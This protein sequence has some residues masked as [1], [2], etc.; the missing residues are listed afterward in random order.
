MTTS[1]SVERR[2]LRARLA[3][4]LSTILCSGLA[5]PAFASTPHPNLDTNDVD[6]TDGTFNPRLPIYAIGSGQGELSLV[7]TPV[8]GNNALDNWSGVGLYQTV[9]GGVTRISISLGATFDT[10]TS[11]DSYAVSL[12][13]TGATLSTSGSEATYH[14]LDGVTITFA[15]LNPQFAGGTTNFCSDESSNF[16]HLLPISVAGKSGMTISYDWDVNPNCTPPQEIDTGANCSEYWRLHSVSNDAGYG[17]TWTY[18][19]PT[20]SPVAAYFQR[21]TATFSN[22]NVPGTSPV[23]TYGYPSSGVQTVTTPGGKVWRIAA[24]SGPIVGIRRPG[25]SNDTTTISYNASATVSSVTNNGITTNYA[26]TVSGSTATM[27]VTDAQAHATTIVSD[28]SK[29]RPTSVTDA[30]GRITTFAYDSVGKLTEVS[31]PEGD[32]KQLGYDAASRTTS[33]TLKAKP[34]SGLSD[35]MTSTSYG[36]D[37]TDATCPAWSR[38]A[39]GHQTDFTYDGTTGLIATVTAPAPASGATRPETRYSYSTVSGIAV[40]TGVSTC[41]TGAAPSCVSTADEVKTTASY[42]SNLLPTSSSIG[43]GDGSLTATTTT[44]YDNI[45]NLIS[46]DGPLLGSDDTTTYRYDP[47]R[48]PV[49]AI[50]ADPDGAGAL[51]RRAV[52]TAYNSDGQPTISEIGNV[53]G[54]TESDWSAFVTMQQSTASYDANARKTKDVVTAGGNTYQVTQYSYDAVG[55]LECSALRMNGATWGALPSSACALGTTGAFGPDRISKT[56]YNAAGEATKVQSAYGTSDQADDATG[57]YN[58]NGT[59]ATLTDAQSNTTTYEYDGFDRLVRTRYPVATAGSVAS[60]TTD[61]EQLSYDAVG[62]VT[63]RRLRDAT[64]INYGYDALNR[65]KT[66][67]LPGSELDLSYGYDLLSRPVSAAT[68][69]QTLAFGYDAL[70][71]NVTQTSPLGTVTSA[72]DIAGRRTRL[73]WPD[74]FYVTYDYLVTGETSAIRENGATSGVGVLAMFGY[75]NLGRRISLT[76]GNGAVTSYTPDAVSRLSTL[77]HSFPNSTS[78]NVT[79]TFGYTPAAQIA[80]STR[81]NDSY[82]WTASANRNDASAVNGLNQA[83]SVGSTSLGYDARGN[84]TSNGSATYSYSSE[85]LLIGTNLGVS[86]AYD[87]L[88]RLSRYT[89]ASGATDTLY[90][91]SDAV[92]DLSSGS[93]SFRYVWGPTPD[94]LLVTYLGAN[95]AT[96]RFWSADE[97]G[98][99]IAAS[100]ASGASTGAFAYDEYGVPGAGT[101]RF[102]YTGQRWLAELGLN[103]Y[104]ARMYAPSLGRFMQTDPIGYGAGMN[105]YGY[106]GSDPINASDPSGLDPDDI[107]VTGQPK[108]KATAPAAT[109]PNNFGGF[110]HSSGSSTGLGTIMGPIFGTDTGEDIVV[111]AT[112]KPKPKP[113]VGKQL[114]QIQNPSTIQC[115]GPVQLLAGNPNNVGK[116]G[117]NGPIRNGSAAVVPSQFTGQESQGPLLRAIGKGA[118]GGIAYHNPDGSIGGEFF[119]GIDQ[120]V[121]NRAISR[122]DI[123]A[124]ANGNLVI[125]IVGGSHTDYNAVGSFTFPNYGQGCP[126]STQ[127]GRR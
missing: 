94:E 123:V 118:D 48:A 12:R 3:L 37:C 21:A 69:V 14:T 23:V 57:T 17:I 59:L 61:Y 58:N 51:K 60:S 119:V 27:V 54:T 11:A 106:V 121:G 98:S 68:T 74:A 4:T 70:G 1:T 28:M 76:R 114:P 96:R 7:A 124:R 52:R 85:N 32:K 20:G 55:R 56:T 117:F 41:Q 97:R 63:S 113:P 105:W 77:A 31:Y 87:P 53:N 49:G 110:F 83:T 71:R 88:D 112:R 44:S 90:D 89:T 125:E 19:N 103:Y 24:P 42:N 35:I 81:S 101:P 18:V 75:D 36:A 66:K 127:P 22:A 65:L 47:D 100:N 50:S 122:A 5:A 64:S 116:P 8:Q 34:G 102:G 109:F 82:A 95:T 25:A 33:V 62:N 93:V 80:S 126:A 78:L 45:G 115:H 46:I 79:S 30:L 13:G 2:R 43:A 26:R 67:D 107:V 39:L 84:L 73:T 99:L 86:L 120:S 15:N 111:T 10:F 16:C 108:S 9:S 92:A 40:V 38:D 6:L 104:K 72:F 91:G 29:F